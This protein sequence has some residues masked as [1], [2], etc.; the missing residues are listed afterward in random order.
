MKESLGCIRE[1]FSFISFIV[2]SMMT[3]SPPKVLS[4]STMSCMN[5]KSQQT[6]T[7]MLGMIPEKVG[8]VL[9]VEGAAVDV[10]MF[11][12]ISN[13]VFNSA[14][15]KEIDLNQVK[16]KENSYKSFI[17]EQ[18]KEA[19]AKEQNKDI[20]FMYSGHGVLCDDPLTKKN[21]WCLVVGNFKRD[22]LKYE[23][24]EKLPLDEQATYLKVTGVKGINYIKKSYMI[25]E[26]EIMNVLK[27]KAMFL[28]SCHS[29]RASDILVNQKNEINGNEGVFVFAASLASQLARGDSN[30]GA[31]TQTIHQF[32]ESI[33]Q[34]TACLMDWEGKGEISDQ[35]MGVASM[36]AFIPKEQVL[37]SI[38]ENKKT[39]I[40]RG[41]SVE[42]IYEESQMST[43][44]AV[45]KCFMKH[46]F[47]CPGKKSKK[48]SDKNQC[49][50]IKEKYTNMAK[51]INKMI[52]NRGKFRS[53]FQGSD[54][55]NNA[56]YERNDD[57]TCGVRALDTDFPEIS[58]E[59]I[60]NMQAQI[61]NPP[62]PT[63][64][65]S[66]PS[67][68]G[69]SV[70]LERFQ[71]EALINLQRPCLKDKYDGDLISGCAQQ[72]YGKNFKNVFQFIDNVKNIFSK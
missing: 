67:Q 42:R 36:L 14:N 5:E 24:W 21:H 49:E 2:F 35:S 45:G 17:L 12:K 13:K 30:G 39:G 56:G 66:H 63:C 69:A 6:T 29:G 1:N 44:N 43:S 31:F 27:P 9:G 46:S 70:Y 15:N 71:N 50:E 48:S 54:K 28:D 58:M 68:S 25:S 16:L 57:G 38:D 4:A 34:E 32:I 60:Q 51:G 19:R 11:K 62:H 37:G 47:S 23:A 59:D 18:M 8:K 7:I 20:N 65:E 72:D 40:H 33:D 53:Y 64:Y 52:E 26:E 61:N 10:N 3:L 41:S 22:Y 55:T